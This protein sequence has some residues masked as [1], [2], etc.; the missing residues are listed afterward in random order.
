M[1][2]SSVIDTT[3][4]TSTTSSTTTTSTTACPTPPANSD[5][6]NRWLDLLYDLF[7]IF[8]GICGGGTIVGFREKIREIFKKIGC[9]SRT[10]PQPDLEMGSTSQEPVQQAVTSAE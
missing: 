5:S 4:T 8:C 3:S 2:G 7:Y 10:V 6:S 9:R 1:F